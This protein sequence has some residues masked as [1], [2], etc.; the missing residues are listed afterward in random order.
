MEDPNMETA[1]LAPR[2]RR[3][4]VR[5]A[6]S[7]ANN[8]YVIG[9]GIG[10]TIGLIAA[11]VGIWLTFGYGVDRSN[12][13][14]DKLEKIGHYIKKDLN[15][16][17]EAIL[18]QLTVLTVKVDDL[19]QDVDELDTKVDQLQTDVT[20]LQEDVFILQENV[21]TLSEEVNGVIPPVRVLC[22]QSGNINFGDF[23]P[24]TPVNIGVDLVNSERYPTS[25]LPGALIA[26]N[27]DAGEF[28]VANMPTNNSVPLE[29]HARVFIR[30]AGGG[31]GDDN[32]FRFIVA[33]NGTD[34]TGTDC[35]SSFFED[36]L[37]YLDDNQLYGTNTMQL[38][39]RTTINVRNG[40]KFYFFLA[41]KGATGIISASEDENSS[42]CAGSFFSF[43]P[44]TRMF[45]QN[46]IA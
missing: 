26:Y 43:Q 5:R 13:I 22:G 11:L 23:D 41:S 14:E 39:I 30:S 2:P 24:D 12:D 37:R 4:R 42:V 20:D 35:P 7:V 33:S 38:E 21:T 44:M 29:I 17:L 3:S 45:K 34:C 36:R 28:E 18:A 16:T 46:L 31:G 32:T 9:F 40:D 25:D 15:P 10:I 8:S 6:L 27:A 19:T 1:D